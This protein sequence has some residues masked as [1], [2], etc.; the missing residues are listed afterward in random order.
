MSFLDRFKKNKKD[1]EDV[2]KDEKEQKAPE[3]TAKIAVEKNNVVAIA[4]RGR[5]LSV[6]DMSAHYR[7]LLRPLISEK[8][9]TA[10]SHL[11]Y[12]FM[13]ARHANKEQIKRA[14]SEIYKVKP[15]K[16]RV[17]NMEGKTARHG[18]SVGRRGDWK[19]AIITLPKGQSISI[20]E[21]V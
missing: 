20:H 17:I 13:V 7:V 8:A 14:I 6:H 11:I 2:K 19:K 18:R 5:A 10:E 1:K 15:Q 9:A 21:G 4:G 12:T 16:V 3:T